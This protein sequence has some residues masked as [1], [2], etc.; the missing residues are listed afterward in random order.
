MVRAC[1]KWGENMKKEKFSLFD[2]TVHFILLIITVCILYPILHVVAVSFSGNYAIMANK[3]SFFPKDLTFGSYEHVLENAKIFTSFGNSVWYTALGVV[4]NVIMTV[5]MAYPLSKDYLAGRGFFM[6]IIVFTLFFSGGTIPTYML[7]KDLQLLD[8][9]WS[10]ILPN[11]I[12]TVQLIIMINFI[13]SIP[14]SLCEAAY[15]DGASEFQVLFKVIMP[16]LKASIAT[17]A[18]SYFMGHWNSYFIPMLY[19]FDAKKF[20]LQLILRSML[21][22]EKE[23]ALEMGSNLTPAG[24]K[25]ATIVLAM[26]PVLV[27]YPLA[28]KYFIKGVMSGSIKE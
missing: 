15:L 19:L 20:P 13:R 25:N 2:G 11:A 23:Q 4:T 21:L 17:I 10:L 14:A 18:L 16:L 7:V 12:W 3:V 6:K 27:I 26:I 28:Q 24:V 8:T 5:T 1:G 9:V 22:E